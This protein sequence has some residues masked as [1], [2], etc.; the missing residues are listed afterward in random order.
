M[1]RQESIAI[2]KDLLAQTR[3]YAGDTDSHIGSPMALNPLAPSDVRSFTALCDQLDFA[4]GSG[5]RVVDG[6]YSWKTWS[7]QLQGIIEGMLGWRSEQGYPP[8]NDRDPL[9][10]W[11]VDV[12]A[13]QLSTISV[14]EF[15]ENAT[16]PVRQA[17]SAAAGVLEYGTP[18]VIMAIVILVLII[19]VH[20]T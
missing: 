11:W 17:A 10:Q 14:G 18:F 12:A 6:T 8:L 2:L 3:Y 19:A 9:A 5:A 15:I 16:E 13:P 7:G 4:K 20:L 1:T